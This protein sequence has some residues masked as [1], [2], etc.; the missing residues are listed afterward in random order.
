LLPLFFILFYLRQ[1]I[2][3]QWYNEFAQEHSIIFYCLGF[4]AGFFSLVLIT[5][6]Y[7][8][9]TNKDIFSFQRRNRLKIADAIHSLVLKK[10]DYEQMLYRGEDPYKDA[11]RVDRFLT[12]TFRF[13]LVRSVRHYNHKMLEKVFRQNHFNALIIQS[14]SITALILMGALVEHQHFRIPASASILLLFSIVSTILGALTYWLQEWRT[15]FILFVLGSSAQFMNWEIF[16][17][18]NQAYGLNY[19]PNKVAYNYETLDS[20]SQNKRYEEDYRSTYRILQN[21]RVKF[22]QRMGYRKPKL[23]LICSS[24]GGSRAGLWSMQVLREIDRHLQGRL[25]DHTILMTGASGGMLGAAYYRELYHQKKKGKEIDLYDFKYVENVAK[26]LANALSFTFLVNDI[27]VPWVD[28]RIS[29]YDY[30]QDRGY[31]FEQQFI[32]NT[33][34]TMNMPLAYYQEPEAKGLIPMMF[35][36]PVIINDG[37]FMVISPQRVS[38][39]MRPPYLDEGDMRFAEIDG[40]DF[41]AMFEQHNPYNLR[42]VTALRTSATYPLIF[43]SVHMPTEPVIELMDAG[44]RDNYGIE[45]ASRFLSVFKNWVRDNTSGVVIVAIR[46]SD[47]VNPIPKSRNRNILSAIFTPLSSVLE[48]DLM[49][50]YHHDNYIAYLRSKL[51]QDKVDILHFVYRPTQLEERASLSL[52]LTQREKN[53]ILNAIYYEDNQKN[54]VRL[55]ELLK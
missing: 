12:E 50:D 13:R 49:Q 6:T 35:L 47:K 29:G 17:Y 7:F 32:E 11:I 42:F 26:D 51:G 39:M 55:K 22:Y 46:A 14:L 43:P 1:I 41:G 45:V 27:F 4:L 20:L 3:F 37:R 52:H 10:K 44:F 54:I 8:Q 19:A 9:L 36:T 23:V 2:Y 33:E 31:M 48:V 18:P 40:V 24:G 30:K 38:Y 25:M 15:L 53:D 5:I 21:W 34:Q 16:Y 28:R